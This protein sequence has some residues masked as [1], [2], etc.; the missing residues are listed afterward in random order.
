V[1]CGGLSI[2]GVCRSNRGRLVPRGC[3]SSMSKPAL[4]V[5][6]VS[7]CEF[8]AAGGA[9]SIQSRSEQ[10][11]VDDSPRTLTGYPRTHI[12]TRSTGTLVGAEEDEAASAAALGKQ[13]YLC[14]W[15]I[16][17]SSAI[18]RHAHA[19]NIRSQSPAVVQRA[20][21][22]DESP[23]IDPNRLRLHCRLSRI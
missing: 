23:S 16:L 19:C 3:S 5:V 7:D 12:Y 14:A 4:C 6:V 8:P 22:A 21:G 10:Q 18:D 2:C 11:A 15:W 17:S 13:V 1:E 9:S 20:M